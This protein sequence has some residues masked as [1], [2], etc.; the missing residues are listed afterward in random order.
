MGLC[1]ILPFKLVDIF[2]SLLGGFIASLPISFNARA[3]A[4]LHRVFPQKDEKWIQQTQY[5]SMVNLAKTFFEF[6]SIYNMRI[7][8]FNK[9]V[10]YKG[11][12]NLKDVENAIILT[13][14]LGNWDI[15]CK[16][17]GNISKNFANVYRATNNPYVNSYMLKTRSKSGGIQI[18]KGTKGA[19]QI[20][21]FM[22]NGGILGMLMDQK[23]NDGIESTFLGQKAMTAPALAELANK[24]KVP[25]I[26][27]SSI[28]K[29]NG[30]FVVT[31][32]PALKLNGEKVADTQL[33]NDTLS[34]MILDTPN[35]WMWVHKR[36]I[37]N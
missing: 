23:M 6:S 22:K 9:M 26:P 33:C 21:K 1:R 3:R 36:F 30:K 31:V 10:E 29:A 13:A 24:Y 27:V 32:L 8:T 11:L 4:N 5:S 25:V 17:M 2:A 7:K 19:R 34:K 16:M 20:V 37:V 14:H 12:D 35:Q 28:R 18:P 15:I